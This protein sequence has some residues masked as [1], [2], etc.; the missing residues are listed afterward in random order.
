M[1]TSVMGLGGCETKA[2]DLMLAW[3][4]PTFLSFAGP[5]IIT[6]LRRSGNQF[7]RTDHYIGI[8]HS[9]PSIIEDGSG[10]IFVGY[11]QS[12]LFGARAYNFLVS[13]KG[14]DGWIRQGSLGVI[15]WD[16]DESVTLL[17][18]PR[19]N[20]KY[21]GMYGAL[22]D[23]IEWSN[24]RQ[25]WKKRPVNFAVMSTMA[26][27]PDGRIVGIRQDPNYG[28]VVAQA[29]YSSWVPYERFNLGGWREALF[30]WESCA[31]TVDRTGKAIVVGT[32]FPNGSFRICDENGFYSTSAISGSFAWK[33]KPA[34][35]ASRTGELFVGFGS[36]LGFQHSEENGIDYAGGLYLYRSVNGGQTFAALQTVN[37]GLKNYG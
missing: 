25:V 20:Q 37:L 10:R 31:V 9:C 14:Y 6:H 17:C 8:P 28:V 18:D 29:P 26:F 1:H 12:L 23:E 11:F 5:L 32:R 22:L 34:L 36:A 4:G 19:S 35:I 30:D 15:G 27:L 16:W 24:N 2:G 21:F 7:L 33:Q 13:V 3:G